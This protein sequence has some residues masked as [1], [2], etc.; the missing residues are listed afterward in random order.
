MA[1][2]LCQDHPVFIKLTAN[3]RPQVFV[4]RDGRER[5]CVVM[6]AARHCNAKP[7]WSAK[8]VPSHPATLRAR[9]VECRVLLLGKDGSEG[10]DLR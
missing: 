3:S 1:L 9:P 7:T 6:D 5:M 2:T 8:G 4:V 10:L